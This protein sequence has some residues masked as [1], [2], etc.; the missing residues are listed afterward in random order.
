MCVCVCVRVIVASLDVTCN[1]TSDKN[2]R[3]VCQGFEINV[4]DELHEWCVKVFKILQTADY[5]NDVESWEFMSLLNPSL[6]LLTKQRFNDILKYEAEQVLQAF[7]DFLNDG[8]FVLFF[9]FRFFCVFS[10]KTI[11]FCFIFFL[12]MCTTHIKTKIK[13]ENKDSADLSSFNDRMICIEV[14]GCIDRIPPRAW[15][16]LNIE[17]ENSENLNAFLLNVSKNKD[18]QGFLKLQKTDFSKIKSA[19][20][21]RDLR[22]AWE[23]CVG[24]Y[25]QF[26]RLHFVYKMYNEYLT[27]Q[28][29]KNVCTILEEFDA[30]D[31]EKR[32]KFCYN[33]NS[34]F[35]FNFFLIFF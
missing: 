32:V 1:S 18:R 17:I 35:F 15:E 28:A 13:I 20:A 7:A 12:N 27:E 22:N 34:C 16:Q 33:K 9:F 31:I 4:P 25:T 11:L 10:D 14:C 5:A 19:Q 24:V 29:K 8:I 30:L 23:Q 26:A 21:H 2:N 3:D 6:Q